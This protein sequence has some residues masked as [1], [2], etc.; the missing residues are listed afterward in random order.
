M[1]GNNSSFSQIRE[2]AGF[3][4]H[5]ITNNCPFYEDVNQQIELCFYM[6]CAFLNIFVFFFLFWNLVYD[7]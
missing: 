1:K 5:D 2:E 4:N 6:E 3:Y 7:F